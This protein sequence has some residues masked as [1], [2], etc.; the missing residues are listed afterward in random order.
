MSW[1]ELSPVVSYHVPPAY[2][3]LSPA[4]ALSIDKKSLDPVLG[5][6]RSILKRKGTPFSSDFVDHS[7]LIIVRTSDY[8]SWEK[9]SDLRIKGI[10]DVVKAIQ[11]EDEEFIGLEDPDVWVDEHDVTHLYFTMAFL[12]KKSNESLCHLGH[13]QGN[14]LQQLKATS[15][16]LSPSPSGDASSRNSAERIILGYKEVAISPVV[17]RGVRLDLVEAEIPGKTVRGIICVEARNM[18]SSWSVKSVAADPS[19]VGLEW[20]EGELSPCTLFP[21]SFVNHGDLLVGILNGR[22]RTRKRAG[23]CVLG[24]YLIGLFLF[25]PSTGEIP[26]ISPKPLIEDPE[27]KGITFASDFIQTNKNEDILYAHVD[28]EFIRAYKLNAKELK[29]LLPKKV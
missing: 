2:K 11:K 19:V 7:K 10:E 14:S 27:A 1:K 21:S 3:E 18:S 6:V 17:T 26:W 23:K 5:V 4:M 8:I 24:K 22:A 9:V 15:P 28:D 13:A 20:C 29:K 25:N 12:R 16:V